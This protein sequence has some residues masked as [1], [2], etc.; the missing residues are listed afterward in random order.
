[1]RAGAVLF[2]KDGTLFDFQKSWG[3]WIGQQIRAMA[4]DDLALAG[5]IAQVLGFDLASDLVTPD[6]IMVAGTSRD[7]ARRLLPFFPDVTLDTLTQDLDGQ[8][9]TMVP[10]EVVP[11]GPFLDDLKARGLRLGVAT[12]DNKAAAIAHLGHSGVV[13]RFEYIAGYDSGYGAKP[14]PGMCSAFAE[15][16]GLHPSLVVMVGDSLHDLHAGR[17]AGMQTVAVL[18]GIATRADLNDH[19]DVVLPDIA[20]LSD[21]LLA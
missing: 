19:A 7:A 15:H 18:T 11:L 9:S 14:D 20:A 2:D 8:A 10:V 16:C 12:N 17:R 1:M 5:A 6:S 21:W 13:D 4:G 3:G